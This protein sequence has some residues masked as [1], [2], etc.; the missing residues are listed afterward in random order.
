M[1]AIASLAFTA[2][3]ADEIYLIKE[4][5][6]GSISNY[7]YNADNQLSRAHD[8]DGGGVTPLYQ[9]FYNYTDG[10]LTEEY[11]TQWKE[12]G[13]WTDPRNFTI[14]TYDEQDRLTSAENT[15]TNR[16]LYYSYN[17]EGYLYQ[18]I[19]MG[20]YAGSTEYDKLYSTS[21]YLNF[22][23][24][25]NP[26]KL[27]YEDGLY[28]SGTYDETYT[29]DEQGR[30]TCKEAYSADGTPKHKYEYTYDEYNVVLSDI[31]YCNDG[32]G[33]FEYQYRTIRTNTGNNTYAC[34]YDEFWGEWI[35]HNSYTEYYATL[36]GEYAPRNLFLANISTDESPNTI[37][38]T[39]D[40]PATEIPDAQYIVWRD[41]QPV[42]TVA[43]VDG[44]ITYTEAGVSNDVKEYF[45]QTYDVTN[46]IGYNIS[47]VVPFDLNTVLPTVTNLRYVKTTLG[48]TSNED[49]TA[50]PVYWVHFEWDAPETSLNILGYKIYD[51]LSWGEGEDLFFVELKTTTS[52][53]DSVSVYRERQY[54]H[55][56]QA[57]STTTMVTV[58]YDLGESEGVIETFPVENAAIE[59]T[60]VDALAYVAGRNLIM[61]EKAQ[62]AIYN[63]AGAVVACYNNASHID[64]SALPAG[65]HIALV[66][67][68]NHTQAFKIAR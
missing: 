35:A 11:Y 46:N 39:C 30:V 38:L 49:G 58:L 63:A 9:Y 50:F 66:K 14:Y 36:K 13:E 20:K 12:K 16:I 28:A 26:A 59:G 31:K 61:T 43:A 8:I 17:E 62:V 32:D 52:T 47:N 22:D 4:V 3:A 2:T 40:V 48:D 67:I 65:T 29:Y 64:L 56:D 23:A 24:N 42:D 44:V 7:F 1:A 6:P 60:R 34:Q 18:I 53:C 25:G 45:I 21:T 10:L 19:S 5:S 54:D 68:G 55:E 27:E 51:V 41:W 33:G 15:M 37:Q 57:H